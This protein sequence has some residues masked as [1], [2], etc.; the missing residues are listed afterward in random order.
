MV[1]H[2]ET[3]RSLLDLMSRC[4][5][6][7]RDVR[8]RHWLI[9]PSRGRAESVLENW[10]RL[11]GIAS[12]AQE[13]E[14]R[15]LIEQAAAGSGS[16]FNFE[17]LRLAVAAALPEVREHPECPVPRDVALQPLSAAV[18]SWADL[19][20][21][22]IDETMLCRLPQA[23]WNPGS[24]LEA[25]VKHTVVAHAL[26][27]HIGFIEEE[28]FA[29]S[30]S[31]W[32]QAWHARGGVPHLWIQLDAGLPTM[33]W[34]R[35][36]LFVRSL[37]EHHAEKIHLFALSP[38]TE[39]WGES[40]LRRGRAT[41][42]AGA[43]AEDADFYPGGLLWAFG[44]RSQDLHRQLAGSFFAE[45]NGGSF[46]E[47]PE[48]RRDLLGKLQESCRRAAALP[49][50]ELLEPPTA[51][52]SF[53]VHS[54]HNTL[55]ELEICRDRILQALRDLPDLR[56]EDI[57]ILLAN[58][59]HQAPL[60]EAALRTGEESRRGLPFRL[61]G[62][63]RSAPGSL[64]QGLLLLLRKLRGR[65]G[66]EDV[67][68]LL[69]EPTVGAKFALA[70][71]DERDGNPISWLRDAGFRWGLSREHRR[72]VQGLDE[73]RWSLEWALQRLGM[74]AV[75]TRQK[76]REK[77]RV[78][79]DAPES[80]PLDRAAG[81]EIQKLAQLAHFVS[82]LEVGR[83]AWSSGRTRSV[84]EWNALVRD[85]VDTFFDCSDTLAEQQWAR[86]QNV[87]LPGVKQAA[88][89]LAME[90]LPDAYIRM[91]EE[92]LDAH[93]DSGARGPGG[94]RVA[95]LR[96][97]AGLP[98]RMILIAGLEEGEFPRQDL[99]P[100]WHPL[101]QGRKVGDISLREADRHAL[102]LAVL[103]CEDRLVITYQ[104][105]SDEDSK[106]RP[107]STAL[108]DLLQAAGGVLCGGLEGIAGQVFHHDLNHFSPNGFQ[109]GAKAGRGNQL[110]CDYQGAEVLQSRVGLPAYRGPWASPLAPLAQ[111]DPAAATVP[112]SRFTL[113]LTEPAKL[114]LHRLGI[115]L[116]EQEAALPS[117]DLLEFHNLS[118][119]E[120]RDEMLSHWVEGHG[121]DALCS[122]WETAGRLPRGLIGSA[123]WGELLSQLPP[124]PVPPWSLD[125]RIACDFHIPLSSSSVD[126]GVAVLGGRLRTGWY[127]ASSGGTAHWYTASSKKQK[128]L[129]QFRMESLALAAGGGKG[130]S[131]PTWRETLAHFQ[132]GE[133]VSMQ[134]PSPEM[135]AELLGALQPLF[136]L[137]HCLPLPFWP[138]IFEELVADGSFA[139]TPTQ[140]VLEEALR[141]AFEKWQTAPRNG[142][143]APAE[144]P[145]TRYVFRGCENPFE[146]APQAEA[147][148][149]LP[150][151]NAPL[152]WRIMEFIRGW[153]ESA[154][155]R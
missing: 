78:S 103:A 133:T 152:S 100:K 89:G 39:Y 50:N 149:F 141:Q 64:Y 70:P 83:R 28:C 32:A 137:A 97:A 101:A 56:Y 144:A 126:G 104:G 13:V 21:R 86:L 73:V 109:A 37:A 54:A 72:E 115:I 153:C 117:G 127:G 92:K 35:F 110:A 118:R 55:R 14:L 143:K 68:A 48:A 67:Q 132:K 93:A 155:M 11:S 8:A 113:L 57:L 71:G 34:E 79:E 20:A 36:Q 96:K 69:E 145:T 38:S 27:A 121:M 26:Q 131:E 114:F 119:W 94:I 84:E 4:L 108:S 7:I 146:W 147:A 44:G 30:T 87:I 142:G 46:Q 22:S 18:L 105:S 1:F 124:A 5:A 49:E 112:I 80:V 107:P 53:T 58:P 17:R 150:S 88:D 24:F 51:D 29:A 15:E 25:L 19:L 52:D 41:S 85:L 136:R 33:E 95:D 10:A 90:F 116:P 98:A 111:S 135:A 62:A 106:Q 16:R 61:T 91:L 45:G 120:L 129:F 6:R 139:S 134:L 77:V 60:L 43:S 130:A 99:R 154:P 102:L 138:D 47:S 128:T 63:G 40:I 9:F 42:H 66:L 59:K 3:P 81:L 123:A 2:A 74:G 122:A 12:H 151:A 125:N 75:M 76:L 23:R 65:L 148:A 82:E 31:E 140:E